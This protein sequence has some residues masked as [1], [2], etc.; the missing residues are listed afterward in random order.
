MPAFF[1]SKAGR[2]R[3]LWIATVALGMLFLSDRVLL[4]GL[5]AKGETLRREITAEEVDLRSGVG[6]QKRR[7]TI[8]TD[9]QRYGHYLLPPA[10][11]RELIGKFLKET[12]RIAQEAGAVILD[13]TPDNQPAKGAPYKLYKAQLKA[14]ATIEQLL[15]FLYKLQTSRLLV[16]LDRFSV[17]PKDERAALVRLETTIS[18]AVP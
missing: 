16:K 17:T 7:G 2:E 18:M 3:T 13:L 8:Q 14:E 4:S 10:S 11:D 12:E 6:L 5:R 15:N 1:K 9:R